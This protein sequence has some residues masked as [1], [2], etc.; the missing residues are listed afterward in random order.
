M[1]IF[2]WKVCATLNHSKGCGLGLIIS[3]CLALLLGPKTAPGLQINSEPDKGTEVFFFLEAFSESQQHESLSMIEEIKTNTKYSSTLPQTLTSTK[4][5]KPSEKS[6]PQNIHTS[7][8]SESIISTHSVKNKKSEYDKIAPEKDF[9]KCESSHLLINQT[10]LNRSISRRKGESAYD[11]QTKKSNDRES[12]MTSKGTEIKDYENPM[13][14]DVIKNYDFRISEILPQFKRQ[15]STKHYSYL[16]E[17]VIQESSELKCDCP[18]VLSVDDDAF[19]LQ[20][21]EMLLR[22]FEKKCVKAFNGEQAIKAVIERN[23]KCKCKFK[24]IFMDYH[25]PVKDGVETTKILRQMWENKEIPEMT[26][27]GCTAFGAKDLVE[28]WTE[29]GM[30]DFITKP[31]SFSKMEMILK[32]WK[33]I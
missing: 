17:I 29:A 16:S 24:L 5:N 10:S 9:I 22:K 28:M 20:S 1:K 6:L 23:K 8:S 33:L 26:I 15:N 31:V 18:E 21:L 4:K 27:I 25:M 12:K 30:A 32:K 2:N 7:S 11:L 3:H 19:N 14:N 13:I